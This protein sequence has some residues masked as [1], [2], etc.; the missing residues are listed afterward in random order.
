MICMQTNTAVPRCPY[1]AKILL[2][3]RRKSRMR[4]KFLASTRHTHW[5]FRGVDAGVRRLKYIVE[6][7][8]ELTTSRMKKTRG[9]I[10]PL[11]REHS[12][13]PSVSDRK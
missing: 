13:H 2:C 9:P 5:W 6:P 4:V 1:S 11:P 12:K 8:A 3:L 7:C 10:H